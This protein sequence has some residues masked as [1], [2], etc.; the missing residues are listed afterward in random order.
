MTPTDLTQHSV[1]D[2]FTLALLIANDDEEDGA[3]PGWDAISEL[4]RRGTEEIF[5]VSQ[6]YCYDELPLK[7]EIGAAV[8][9]QLN[10]SATYPF[11][12]QT[13]PI[14]FHLIE[15]DQNTDVLRAACIALGHLSDERAV[16]PLLTLKNHPHEDVRY[17]VVIGLLTQEDEHA[18]DAL[19]E[20]SRD[21][22]SDVR[23]WATFGLGQQIDTD[24]EAIREA[25]FA[26]IEDPDEQTRG[27]AM[28]GLAKRKDQRVFPIVLDLLEKMAYWVLPLEAAEYLADPRLLP[29]L[30]RI[31]EHWQDVDWRYS[32]LEDAIAA[33]EGKPNVE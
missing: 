20:L 17:G 19:I 33:C 1:S 11:R 16:E 4:R 28:S 24:T 5:V 18:I 3:T 29:A 21:T 9:G 31:K 10:W 25:L 32:R 2:L 8:L 14:L 26:R 27:E 12:E 22:D 13:L 7:R 23:D 30:Y 15:T 6:S